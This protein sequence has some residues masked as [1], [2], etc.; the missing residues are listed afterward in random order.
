MDLLDR[1][2]GH[3]QWASARL[4][5]L[6]RGLTDARMDQPFDVGHRTLRATFEH[7]ISSVAFWTA[8]M[9]GQRVDVQPDDHL[10][11]ALIDRHKFSHAA[12]AAFARGVRD[13]RRLDDTFVDHIGG[14]MTLGGGIIH[15]VL[16]DAEHRDEAL[17]I[18]RRLGVSDLPEVDHAIW[19]LTARGA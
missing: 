6:S 17:H 7:M 8:M 14:R 19:D 12:F 18:L 3:D 5:D 16:H 13:E 15:V 10:L 9:A 4:L 1:M 2:L 11:A